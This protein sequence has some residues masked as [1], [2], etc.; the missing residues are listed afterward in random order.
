MKIVQP[1]RENIELEKVQ[2]NKWQ[3]QE[4][5]KPFYTTP[6]SSPQILFRH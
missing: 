4:V 5:I 1:L 2:R 3:A 6:S